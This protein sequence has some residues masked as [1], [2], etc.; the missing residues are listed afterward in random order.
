VTA[1]AF[2]NDVRAPISYGP[3]VKA[4]VAYLL[5]RQHLPGRRVAETEYSS[6]ANPHS[7]PS[8]EQTNS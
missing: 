7:R 2:P 1:G 6:V 4:L 3:R 8:D 5:A